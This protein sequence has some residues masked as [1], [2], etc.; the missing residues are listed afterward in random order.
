MQCWSAALIH[1]EKLADNEHKIMNLNENDWPG[2]NK[3][4]LRFNKMMCTGAL[5]TYLTSSSDLASIQ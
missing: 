4:F 2:L 1:T 3:P 5:K